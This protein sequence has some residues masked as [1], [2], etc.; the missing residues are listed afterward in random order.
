MILCTL[1]VLPLV[2]LVSGPATIRPC[3]GGTPVQVVVGLIVL[4][5]AVAVT[6]LRNRLA[7]VLVVGVT[8]YGCGAFFIFHGAPDPALTQFLTETLVLVIFLLVLRTLLA[9]ADTSYMRRHRLPR[10][11]IAVAVGAAVTTLGVYATAARTTR[12]LADLL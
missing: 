8:G 7:A 12:P 3:A 11:L 2:V 1:T 10:A 4:A 5:A 9:E 6:A